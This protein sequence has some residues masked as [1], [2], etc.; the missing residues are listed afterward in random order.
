[1]SLVK[2]SAPRA[3]R[4]LFYRCCLSE[5]R[6][7]SN[8]SA[9]V[10]WKKIHDGN[11][12]GIAGQQVKRTMAGKSLNMKTMHRGVRDMLFAIRGPLFIRAGE[13]EAELRKVF[14]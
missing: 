11:L 10:A 14:K 2:M 13:I 9:N 6:H 7:I 12:M 1:M 8:L 5:T 4:R 3:F